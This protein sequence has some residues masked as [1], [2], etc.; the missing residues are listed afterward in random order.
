MRMFEG[1]RLLVAT[2]NPGKLREIDDLVRPLGI[3]TVSAA[4]LDLP[5]PEETEKT[6]L[7]NATLKATAA[8][9][10]AGLVALADDSGLAVV[11]LG[12]APGVYSARWAG[13][14]KDFGL[15]MRRVNEKLGKAGD[16]H[17]RFVCALALAW[18]DG[19]VE[20][21]EGEVKGVL[22]WPARGKFGFGYDP[23]F[24]PEGQ[25]QTFGEMEP[26]EKHAIS[27]R[28]D[29]FAKLLAGPLKRG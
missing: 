26:A 16:R 21:V 13:Q 10:A 7:G 4:E 28:A 18:P 23:M 12:G 20:A 17:A 22:V 9:A 1:E 11:G 15:A 6:F 5:E 24:V 14:E 27:H 29:A 3:A 19:H 25:E 8:A 2:H